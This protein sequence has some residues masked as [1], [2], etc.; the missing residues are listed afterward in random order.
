ML[1]SILTISV[2]AI[3][4]GADINGSLNIL[5]KAEKC[6][7]DLVQSMRDKGNWNHPKCIRVAY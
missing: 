1:F 3:V 2:G 4:G 5:R 7:P 6:I